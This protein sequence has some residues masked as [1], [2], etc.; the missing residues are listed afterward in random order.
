MNWHDN[1]SEADNKAVTNYEVE[2]SNALVDWAHGRISM[3]EAR[4]IVAKCNKAIQKIAEG[5]AA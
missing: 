4:E 1:L 3:S 2:R 5:G